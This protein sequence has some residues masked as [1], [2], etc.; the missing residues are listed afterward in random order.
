[1]KKIEILFK[2][3]VKLYSNKLINFKVIKPLLKCL[4]LLKFVIAE[5]F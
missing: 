1:M 2:Y 4:L 5:I 3:K